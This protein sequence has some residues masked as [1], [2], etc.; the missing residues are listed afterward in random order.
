MHGILRPLPEETEIEADGWLYKT[1]ARMQR[2]KVILLLVVVPSLLTAAYY[3]LIA[4]DQYESAAHFVVRSAQSSPAGSSGLSSLLAWGGGLNQS[5]SDAKSVEDYL[6]STEAVLA[7]DKKIGLVNRFRDDSADMLTR[8]K[9]AAPTPE[10]LVKYYRKHVKFHF[11][12]DSGITEMSVRTFTPKDSL[13]I[14]QT[15]LRMG[16]DRIN[17]LNERTYSDSLVTATRQLKEAEDSLAAI[18]VEMTHFRS[19]SSDIDPEGTGKAQTSLVTQM[20]S[21]LSTARAQLQTMNGIISHSSPQ[22]IALAAHVRA[23]EGQVAV[24]ERKLTGQGSIA[25]SLGSYE[26]LRVR[27]EFAAKRYEAA[28]AA[29]QSAREDARKKRLYLIRVVNPNMPVKAL[30]PERGRIVLTTFLSLLAI[31]AVG[32]LML[33]GVKEHANV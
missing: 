30:F 15:L 18:Q 5:E 24:Q 12:S 14:A 16:E 33:A 6:D 10:A 11:D 4:A 13:L 19:M 25:S 27:Q 29:Y 1:R 22:Y 23:L 20:S 17:M 9:S 32:W 26:S 28:A 31:Y 2:N 21:V 3:Y 7:L 8:L